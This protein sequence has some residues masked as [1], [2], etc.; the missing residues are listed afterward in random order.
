ML[1]GCGLHFTNA[2]HASLEVTTSVLL[3]TCSPKK[4]PIR[5]ISKRELDTEILNVITILKY[6]TLWLNK[7]LW[8][9]VKITE[10]LNQP[11]SII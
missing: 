2:T 8:K 7:I 10:G 5:M 6:L 11:N 4:I 9:C 1:G 3:F